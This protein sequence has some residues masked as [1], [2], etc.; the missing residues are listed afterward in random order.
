MISSFSLYYYM[1][2]HIWYGGNCANAS[3]RINEKQCYWVKCENIITCVSGRGNI[4]NTLLDYVVIITKKL[5]IFKPRES[6]EYTI[7]KYKMIISDESILNF[8]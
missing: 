6:Q 2:L 8:I 7:E 1:V 3:L 5:L 4:I